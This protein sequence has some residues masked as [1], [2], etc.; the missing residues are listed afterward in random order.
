MVVGF[1]IVDEAFGWGIVVFDNPDMFAV[2]AGVD[3]PAT[4]R[5]RAIVAI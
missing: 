2:F 5:G 3:D 4:L 1:D